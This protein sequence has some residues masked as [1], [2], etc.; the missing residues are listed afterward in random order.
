MSEWEWDVPSA[1][2]EDIATG[3]SR[4]DP[5]VPERDDVPES[6]LSRILDTCQMFEVG[7]ETSTLL[8]TGE[9]EPLPLPDGIEVDPGRASGDTEA[10]EAAPNKSAMLKWIDGE[11]SD[12]KEAEEFIKS[13]AA[14]MVIQRL[15]EHGDQETLQKLWHAGSKTAGVHLV[16][17]RSPRLLPLSSL[18]SVSDYV[19]GE[20]GKQ[21]LTRLSRQWRE[22]ENSFSRHVTWELSP[23]ARLDANAAQTSESL[24]RVASHTS[25]VGEVA[26]LLQRLVI[27]TA[28]P[29]H[30]LTP[31][32]AQCGVELCVL[33]DKT[34]SAG[35]GAYRPPIRDYL[36]TYGGP[37]LSVA[38]RYRLELDN[39]SLASTQYSDFPT[40]ANLRSAGQAKR[41]ARRNAQM[42][43]SWA[44]SALI[45]VDRLH[46]SDEL[47][48]TSESPEVLRDLKDIV[49][50]SAAFGI[51]LSDRRANYFSRLAKRFCDVSGLDLRTVK[52]KDVEL[53]GLTWS[54][55]TTW[56]EE[57]EERVR[58][59]SRV[60]APQ[61]YLI[62]SKMKGRHRESAIQ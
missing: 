38:N 22:F 60:I 31:I 30:V 5:S 42:L 29:A 1:L 14:E 61:T 11:I 9:R 62:D 20:E 50:T 45:A 27:A 3:R 28:G 7:G 48:I 36:R 10:A 18:F 23:Q 56:P 58:N 55:A 4:P 54:D 52:L 34:L 26:R 32:E 57:W 51:N 49:R 46:R 39:C 17:L 33:I 19:I 44:M 53:E 24:L 25:Q 35:K 43:R 6:L 16:E 37:M 13:P 40:A 8:G 12:P 15:S 47:L 41:E 59:R 21:R 2:L